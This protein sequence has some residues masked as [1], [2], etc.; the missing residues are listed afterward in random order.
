LDRLKS[1][2]QKIDRLPAD[3][4]VYLFKDSAGEILY[5]GKA[6]NLR[7][8]VRSYLQSPAGDLKTLSMLKQVADLDSLVTTN[9]K[10]ALILEDNL[11]KEH[12]PRYNVKLRDDKNYPCLRLSLEE[13]SPVLS[14]ARRIRKD[15]A[16]Y[17]GPY[18]SARSLRETL[19]L[20][21]QLFPIRTSL[22]TKFTQC[23]PTW[24]KIDPARYRE[25]VHQVRMFLEGRNEEL[26]ESLKKR[27]EEDSSGLNFEAAARIRDQIS[28]I[29][30]VIEKQKALSTDFM[31]RDVLGIS[32]GEEGMA[33]YLLFVRGGRLLGGKGC[34]FPPSE[35]PDSEVLQSFIRQ[36]YLEGKFIPS[37]VLIPVFLPDQ[38]LIEAWL[39]ERREDKVRVL[40]PRRGA[41][42]DLLN[43][44][45]ENAEKFLISRAGGDSEGLLK[46]L[47]EK[48]HLEKVPRRIEAF[49]ISN[50]Q[51]KY[52]VGSMV[53]FEDGKPAKERYRLFRI[54]T[55]PGADD[56]GM[57]EEVL[58][59]RYERALAA[60]DLP[61]LVLLDGGRGQLNVAREVFK[62][63]QIQGVAL[64]S[65]AKERTTAGPLSRGKIEEKVYHPRYK[66]F[67]SLG[68]HSSLL[69]FLDSVRDEAHRFAIAYHKKIRS[70]GTIQSI[71][72]EIPGIG[73]GRQKELLEF[74]GS[75]DKIK[76]ASA[77][78]LA[79]VPRMGR[80]AAQAVYDF[81]R[82][83]P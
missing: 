61:D 78:E 22:D 35:L 42:R 21:R 45:E 49:D 10:E 7:Q 14:I 81:F 72:G 15:G 34:F 75:V 55:V 8:R 44:A 71:L 48:L 27:M 51:G 47:Q 5:V 20:I 68:K 17:F 50:Y 60:K 79:R 59:R 4:G 36:Y 1:L 77:Q 31:D 32:R 63:L 30:K 18:P 12:H 29:E 26:A 33:V 73:P 25:T 40:V 2:A 66:S 83:Y 28:H 41:K 76:E 37:Q 39:G 65:L 38:A 9:E 46:T 67:L 53:N 74:F 19:K 24:A 70:K 23:M 11:I 16:L 69:N 80:R 57:M 3:P 64:I 13:E 54:K 56:Y 82:Q 43:L 58:R 6:A 52:A 62:K